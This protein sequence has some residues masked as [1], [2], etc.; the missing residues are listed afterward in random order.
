MSVQELLSK[1]KLLTENNY[2]L[3]TTIKN[4]KQSIKQIEKD[5]YITCNHN[6][7]YDTGCTFDDICK[8]KCSICN[9]Y[10][11]PHV[12]ELPMNYVKKK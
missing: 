3:E 5:I 6:W 7:I 8:Y 12:Y 1:V 10:R 9:L 2:L 11:M 4:N